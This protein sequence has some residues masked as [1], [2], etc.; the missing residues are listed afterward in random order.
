MRPS[1]ETYGQ[2]FGVEHSAANRLAIFAS[3]LC[4]YGYV[5]LPQCAARK[6][7]A[8]T[9]TFNLATGEPIRVKELIMALA[10]SAGREDLVRLG[11]RPAAA[12]EPPLILADMTKTRSCLDWTPKFDLEQGAADTIAAMRSA[13]EKPH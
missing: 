5:S 3:P 11:A 8:H 6:R 4:A 7:F 9:G 2:W 12:H 10:R 1:S 13:L